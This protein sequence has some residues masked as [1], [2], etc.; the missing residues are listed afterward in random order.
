MDRNSD[1]NPVSVDVDPDAPISDEERILAERLRDALADRTRSHED[2]DFARSLALSHE[3]GEISAEEHRAI[4]ERAIGLRKPRADVVPLERA[5]L[6]K[7][8]AVIAAGVATVATLAAGAVF[9]AGRLDV[10]GVPASTAQASAGLV[11]VRSTQSLF[12]EPFAKPLSHG[13]ASARIDR[14]YVARE[15][16][17]RE[18]RFAMWGVR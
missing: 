12:D 10:R 2:A 15:S 8:G 18:N 13:A 16:D 7:R 5:R 17:L 9:I 11:H 4:V 6:R 14:I 1:K 3:P